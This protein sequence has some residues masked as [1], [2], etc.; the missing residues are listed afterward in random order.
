[1]HSS[2]EIPAEAINAQNYRSLLKALIELERG[3]D[4]KIN[5]SALSQRAGFSSRSYIR[6]VLDGKKRLVLQ[7][8]PRFVRALR[9]N[10]T[11]E[12]LLTCLVAL[13]E[14]EAN[15]EGLTTSQLKERAEA[16]REKLRR[17][18]NG[19]EK[20]QDAFSFGPQALSVFAA[21]GTPEQGADLAQIQSRSG[22][23]AK[24][25]G[26]ILGEM[27]RKGVITNT[28]DRYYVS[29]VNLDLSNLGKDLA[30]EQLFGNVLNDLSRNYRKK[31]NS[32]EELLFYSAFSIR[33]ERLPELK[34]RFRE[35]LLDMIDT[36]QT[37]DGDTV[38]RS[39]FALYL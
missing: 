36:E 14:K 19:V 9:L 15:I 20:R 38:V 11:T 32:H 28:N 5:L 31:L 16:L 37:D 34:K 4:G 6:E 12:A 8:L 30:F 21:L 26:L 29:D 22:A 1:V 13:E 2:S 35:I 24:T 18:K 7:S 23:D 3:R 39:V 17:R 33:R 27:I 10:K 25:C